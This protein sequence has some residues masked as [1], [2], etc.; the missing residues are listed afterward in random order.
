M[1]C[2]MPYK[3][4]LNSGSATDPNLSSSCDKEVFYIQLASGSGS[5]EY[6]D[7]IKLKKTYGSCNDGVVRPAGSG[8]RDRDFCKQ[9]T[10][11]K[12]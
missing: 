12:D 10:L 7:A 2:M 6:G 1:F 8:E 11:I 5:I 9:Y 3:F 4:D